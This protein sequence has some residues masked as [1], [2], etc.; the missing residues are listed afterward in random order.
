MSIYLNH[1]N[2]CSFSIYFALWIIFIIIKLAQSF[3]GSSQSSHMCKR[4]LLYSQIIK[5]IGINSPAL[6]MLYKL[7]T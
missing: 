1:L 3:N 5:H 2:A 7:E 4:S 6:Y